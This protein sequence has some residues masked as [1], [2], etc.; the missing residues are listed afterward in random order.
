M[1]K[2][3]LWKLFPIFLTK[4]NLEW[5]SWFYE[6]QNH[7][8]TLLSKCE[9]KQINHIGSTAIKNIWAKPI[10]DILIE[11]DNKE[12]MQNVSELLEKNDYIC[13]RIESEKRRSFNKGYTLQGF[14]EKVF[15]LH[16]RYHGDND[17]IYFRDYLSKH[18]EIA[19]LYEELKLNLWRLYKYDRDSYTEAKSEFVKKYTRIAK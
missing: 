14:T 5:I 4:H 10:I 13:M 17:E 18:T 1:T 9:I 19:K 8:R 11:L 12:N 6:E 15:H 16:L 3:E 7:L 2:E